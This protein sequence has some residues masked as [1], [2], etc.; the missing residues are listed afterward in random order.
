M[1][2]NVAWS[3][4]ASSVMAKRLAI[5]MVERSWRVAIRL[6]W[7]SGGWFVKKSI[8]GEEATWSSRCSRGVK[9]D[10]RTMGSL[11]LVPAVLVMDLASAMTA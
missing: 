5:G 9:A 4:G 8:I 10:C 1:F 7:C 6:T 11:P 2:S 3:V